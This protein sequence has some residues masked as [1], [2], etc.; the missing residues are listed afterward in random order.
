MRC[1]YACDAKHL[2][3]GIGQKKTA[4]DGNSCQSNAPSAALQGPCA[5]NGVWHVI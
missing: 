1:S 5:P 3:R 4:P 2:D